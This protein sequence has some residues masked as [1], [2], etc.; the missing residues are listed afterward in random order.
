MRR[1]HYVNQCLTPG[2]REE[3]QLTPLFLFPTKENTHIYTGNN[4]ARYTSS[5]L[6]LIETR[7]RTDTE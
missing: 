1:G 5:T 4:K 7:K 6:D 3:V 2:G